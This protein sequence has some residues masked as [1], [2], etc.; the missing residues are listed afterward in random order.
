MLLTKFF[1]A[2]PSPDWIVGVSRLELCLRNCSWV[3]HKVL[4]LYPYDAG[5]DSGIAYIVSTFNIP[6]I[7]LLNAFIADTH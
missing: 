2:D 5:T 1:Y 4:N 7:F 6:T 3:E